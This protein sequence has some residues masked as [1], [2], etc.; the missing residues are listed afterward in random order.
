M[1][2]CPELHP[3]VRPVFAVQVLE[4]DVLV[5]DHGETP[6]VVDQFGKFIG[7][8]KRTSEA[9]E[10]GQ[11]SRLRAQYFAGHV[12]LNI[13]NGAD[14]SAFPQSQF[15]VKGVPPGVAQVGTAV[16][17]QVQRCE[18]QTWGGAVPKLIA[19]LP[20]LTQWYSGAYGRAKARRTARIV[21]N[22]PTASQGDAK[23]HVGEDT[24]ME[25]G[26]TKDFNVADR[27]EAW[28]LEDEEMEDDERSK[29]TRFKV[30]AVNDSLASMI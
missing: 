12:P 17:V 16:I 7:A 24:W 22:V 23:V 13:V 20:T 14:F 25:G 2:M 9:I 26:T 15:Q 11:R 28:E 5:V 6:T 19:E 29:T 8:V 1:C 30:I 10:L 18:R 3:Q 21:S 4:S 27:E